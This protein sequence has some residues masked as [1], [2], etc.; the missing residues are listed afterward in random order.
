MSVLVF[1]RCMICGDVFYSGAGKK[2]YCPKCVPSFKGK[3]TNE[4]TRMIFEALNDAERLERKR[5]LGR[6]RWHK[7]MEDPVFREH[8]R[9]R[10]LAR[11][12]A[13]RKHAK[14]TKGKK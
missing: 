10:S 14:E 1:H 5:A 11:A 9:L 7:K 3:T 2:T 6:V 8:E 4:R 12:R 13:D